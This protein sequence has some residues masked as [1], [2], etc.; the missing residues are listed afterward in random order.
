M[1]YLGWARPKR[2]PTDSEEDDKVEDKAMLYDLELDADGVIVGGQWRAVESGKPNRKNNIG[3]FASNKQPDFFWVVTKDW[4]KW[5]QDV[6]DVEPWT[7]TKSA[8]PASWKDRAQGAHNF[9][10]A[11]THNF[12]WN[13]RCKITHKKTKEIITV[14]CEY[15]ESKPQPFINLVSKLIELSQ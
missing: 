3:D 12:G 10:Y 9:M 1:T 2:N 14:P 5:F 6:E 8:P 7:D 13:E 11:K 15:K 4:K